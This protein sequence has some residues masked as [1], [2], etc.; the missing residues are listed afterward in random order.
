MEVGW[1][2]ASSWGRGNPWGL[3]SPAGGGCEGEAVASELS[4][5][6]GSSSVGWKL[7][8]LSHGEMAASIVFK[9]LPQCS[10]KSHDDL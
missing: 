10:P 6:S 2:G 1:P 7:M 5:T 3:S 8:T 4:P 9:L